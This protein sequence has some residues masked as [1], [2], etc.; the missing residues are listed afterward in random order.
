MPI[1]RP[2]KATPPATAKSRRSRAL[3]ALVERERMLD[4]ADSVRGAAA[5]LLHIHRMQL[6]LEVAAPEFEEALEF[7]IIR[8]EV[9]FLPD[10]ALQQGG[11][12]RQV[13]DDLCG[14]EPVPPN[15]QLVS[16]HVCTFW[17]LPCT[18]TTKMRV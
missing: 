5:A 7:G 8:R 6:A 14:G 4:V 11:M 3:P 1:T 13:I 12:V 9:E 15:L 2:D 16:G 17:S 18:G 10:E